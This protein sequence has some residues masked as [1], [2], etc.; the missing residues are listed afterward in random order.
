ASTTNLKP[1]FERQYARYLC[2]IAEHFRAAPDPEKLIFNY[3]SPVNEPQIEWGAGRQEGNRACNDDIRRILVALHDEILA[4]KLDVEIRSA[5]SSLVPDLWR[6]NGGASRRWG[7]DYGNYLQAFLHD[8]SIAALLDQTICY[9]DYSSFR[10]PSVVNDHQ[11]LGEK[12]ID[13][14]GAK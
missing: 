10:G 14:P 8:P 5:E 4:R 13:Y 9:H 2:D 6:L 11:I 7:A 1:G 12:M 3:L